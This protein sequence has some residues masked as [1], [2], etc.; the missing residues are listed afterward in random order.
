[1]FSL[2]VDLINFAVVP[3]ASV[4]SLRLLSSCNQF[5]LSVLFLKKI[6]FL[7]FTFIAFDILI[8]LLVVL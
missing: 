1:M 5:F 8:L 4:S 2:Q 6:K 3:S 7:G